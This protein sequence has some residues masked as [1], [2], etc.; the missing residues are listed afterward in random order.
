MEN[1][2]I[3]NLESGAPSPNDEIR[4]PKPEST[5]AFKWSY[6]ESPKAEQAE[7]KR[8]RRRDIIAYTVVAAVSFALLYALAVAMNMVFGW[9]V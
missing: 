2:E 5:Y 8:Q 7:K 1:N 6:T 4:L 9:N 3:N